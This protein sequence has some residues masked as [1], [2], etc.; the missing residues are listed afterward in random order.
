MATQ[1][2]FVFFSAYDCPA[3]M[4]V[5]EY[6]CHVAG[7]SIKAA[8]LLANGTVDIAINWPGGWH[9]AKW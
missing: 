7:A 5:Y 4:N 8:E 1:Y 3:F 9:H 2:C 6:A